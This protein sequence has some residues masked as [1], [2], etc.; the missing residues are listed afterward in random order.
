[1]AV[2]EERR[3][4]SKQ[5]Y[6][7][8]KYTYYIINFPRVV[9]KRKNDALQGVGVRPTFY[10]AKQRCWWGVSWG[11]AR[12]THKICTHIELG[13]VIGSLSSIGYSLGSKYFR[14]ETNRATL[15]RDPCFFS[16]KVHISDSRRK[17]GEGDTHTTQSQD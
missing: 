14:R 17:R 10:F 5:N 6:L 7:F 3:T 12:V 13:D 4:N 2:G 8:T 1:M 16:G 15:S 11:W 9:K